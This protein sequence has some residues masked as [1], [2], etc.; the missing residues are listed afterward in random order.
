MADDSVY[1]PK[2]VIWRTDIVDHIEAVMGVLDFDQNFDN[3]YQKFKLA[4]NFVKEVQVNI[5]R[6]VIDLKE[7]Y[8]KLKPRRE[9]IYKMDRIWNGGC[10]LGVIRDKNEIRVVR[11]EFFYEEPPS[12]F[13]VKD[14]DGKWIDWKRE[15]IE[16]PKY[17]KLAPIQQLKDDTWGIHQRNIM[18]TKRAWEASQYGTVVEDGKFKFNTSQGQIAKFEANEM[19]EATNR[20]NIISRPVHYELSDIC[21][22]WMNENFLEFMSDMQGIRDFLRNEKRRRSDTSDDDVYNNDEEEFVI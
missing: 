3:E 19:N 5:K 15:V 17:K 1:Q 4:M 13:K 9:P 6:K 12:T 20:T 2:T 11:R 22:Y 21:S 10:W 16:M 7:Q 14:F 8:D 18:D